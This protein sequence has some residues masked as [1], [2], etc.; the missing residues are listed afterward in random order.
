MM[1]F[2]TIDLPGVYCINLELQR[3]TRGSFM[4]TYCKQEFAT[5]GFQQEFV[6]M[7]HSVNKQRGTVRGLHVQLPPFAEYKLIRCIRGA[8]FDVVVDLRRESPTFL[9]WRGVE[10]SQ[11]NQTMILIPEGCAHGFQTLFDETELLYHHT[12]YYEPESECTINIFDPQLD[13]HLPLSVT[14]I[15]DKD[16]H[17][18]FIPSEFEGILS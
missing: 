11:D 12:S 3:D 1:K 5:I 17:C 15:S 7:N 16:R 6:Q 10:L 14:E 4:R 9:Q 18:P 8:V 2:T 13:I